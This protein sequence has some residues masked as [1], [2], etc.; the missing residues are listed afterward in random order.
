MI[1]VSVR[2]LSQGGVEVLLRKYWKVPNSAVE[3]L[4]YDNQYNRYPL[5]KKAIAVVV[6]IVAAVVVVVVVVA[7]IVI[8]KPAKTCQKLKYRSII[9]VIAIGGTY[10]VGIVSIYPSD[11]HSLFSNTLNRVAIEVEKKN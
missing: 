2:M 9:T 7:V 6:A 4:L 10:N 3:F 8:A 1:E 5:T 11:G